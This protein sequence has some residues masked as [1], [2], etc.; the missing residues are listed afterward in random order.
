[1]TSPMVANIDPDFLYRTRQLNER[2]LMK[3][4]EYS[5]NFNALLDSFYYWNKKFDD[6]FIKYDNIFLKIVTK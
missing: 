2:V 4:V 6:G 3:M 1:M 5:N